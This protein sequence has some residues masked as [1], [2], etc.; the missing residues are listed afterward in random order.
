MYCWNEFI[1]QD[2][3]KCFFVRLE[4]FNPVSVK[5]D[6]DGTA[7]THSWH[8]HLK[9]KKIAR[10]SSIIGCQYSKTDFL[11]LDIME[12]DFFSLKIVYLPSK[13]TSSSS[14]EMW[15]VWCLW[16]PFSNNLELN[17][18]DAGDKYINTTKWF[19]LHQLHAANS[20]WHHAR[21]SFS[22]TGIQLKK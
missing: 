2:R 13:T 3:T 16:V 5:L 22:T 21:M 17:I 10:T 19:T 11:H 20:H 12:Q 18:Q 14:A 6:K 15:E 8:L 9:W 4:R 1:Y 7:V